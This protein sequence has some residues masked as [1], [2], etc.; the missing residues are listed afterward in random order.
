MKLGQNP[1]SDDLENETS[2]SHSPASSSGHTQDSLSADSDLANRVLDSIE[3]NH[4]RY[5][6]DLLENG[7]LPNILRARIDRY[8]SLMAKLQKYRPNDP[9]ENL[10]E[11]ARDQLGNPNPNW[12]SEKPLT[13]EERKLL[14]QFREQ[15]QI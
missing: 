5:L 14:Q 10:D 1:P 11:I 15:H 12:Q 3:Q 8:K 6:V 13:R 9:S 2:Q 4:P 7:N